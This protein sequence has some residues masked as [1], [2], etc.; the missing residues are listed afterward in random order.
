MKFPYQPGHSHCQHSKSGALCFVRILVCVFAF[1]GLFHGG[2]ARAWQDAAPS[3]PAN[4]LDLSD[5][6]ALEQRGDLYMVRKFYPEAIGIYNRLIALQPKNAL[7][8]NKLGI[9]Y[10]QLQNLDAAK[11]A[12]RAAI[13]LNPRYPEATNNLAAVEY[14]QKNYRS[15]IF[16]Y[17]KAL[18]LAP[19][20]AVVYSNLGT[21]YFA[22][23]KYEYAMDCYRYAL[24]RDPGI[25]D[26]SG[27][28]GAIVHQRGAE[29][30]ATFNFYLAK[31]YAGLG[32][33]ENTLLYISKAWESGYKDLRKNL[34]DKAFAFLVN[35]PRFLELIAR[36]DAEEQNSDASAN[37]P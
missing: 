27:R 6:K 7:Y 36:L 26:R 25:F 31:T 24:M 21:A 17:L 14:A 15:A 33:V 16:T 13:R 4:T 32:D 9:A 28:T 22:Y 18:E 11:R 12:Y 19:G 2:G 3:P 5:P 1:G 35:E 29:D 37:T 34:D 10:H 8:Q 23:K 30:M 20:D